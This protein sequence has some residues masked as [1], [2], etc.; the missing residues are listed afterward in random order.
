MS[1]TDW[2][3]RA[4]VQR[5]SLILAGLATGKAWGAL[6]GARPLASI[7]LI[8][9]I[10]H[11]NKPSAGNRFYRS[12][13]AKVDFALDQLKASNPDRLVHLGDLVDSHATVL[14]EEMA[15]RT[16]TQRFL[17]TGIPFHFVMGNHCL[18][19]MDKKRFAE[20]T[21]TSGTYHA[22]D[23]N[24]VRFL[25]LDACYRSDGASYANGEFDWQDSLIPDS[26]LSWIQRELS[27]ARGPC[28]VFTHQLIDYVPGMCVRNHERVRSVLS[29]AGNVAA[30]FQGH[31]H[32][33]RY[34]V[35]E[36]VPYAVLR[37]V[38]EGPEVQN[39]GFSN[40]T[41]YSD[42]S[43]RLQG[44]AEQKCYDCAKSRTRRFQAR[45]KTGG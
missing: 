36:G 35:V 14:A 10:H 22:F 18:S 6:Q 21:G 41:V 8:T 20:V 7:G 9:D 37:S 39:C 11:A 43:L 1:N 4:F 42:G 23:I 40:L 28:V 30:V 33:N 29:K 19:A 12:S 5:G 27:S 17:N 34:R 32:Q 2:T 44:Y 3:R 38:I 24:G 25:C 13:L 26:Q 45:S 16:V 15:A 31:F